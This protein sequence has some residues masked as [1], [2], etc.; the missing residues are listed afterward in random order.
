MPDE[1]D[2]SWVDYTALVT[3]IAAGIIP[4]VG[5]PLGEVITEAIPRL[6]QDRVVQY[7]R[8]LNERE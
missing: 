2:N 3:K 6:R 8:Q 5:G 7:L 4:I 1:L